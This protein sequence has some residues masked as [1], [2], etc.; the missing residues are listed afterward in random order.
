MPD[1]V[2][3]RWIQHFPLIRSIWTRQ[4]WTRSLVPTYAHEEIMVTRSVE[5][6]LTIDF[7]IGIGVFRV[8]REYLFD[9]RAIGV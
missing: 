4:P 2:P 6:E 9:D 3:S 5:D 8:L 1:S 7:P